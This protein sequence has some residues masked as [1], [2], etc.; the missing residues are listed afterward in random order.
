MDM[1]LLTLTISIKMQKRI[2]LKNIWNIWKL[3]HLSHDWEFV[4][5][6]K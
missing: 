3:C 4:L 2:Q 5:G 1:K 6:W